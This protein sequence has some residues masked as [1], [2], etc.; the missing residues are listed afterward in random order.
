MAVHFLQQRWTQGHNIGRGNSLDSI[1]LHSHMTLRG[2]VLIY[3][4]DFLNM[5]FHKNFLQQAVSALSAKLPAFNKK[6]LV[7]L[8]GKND[9]TTCHSKI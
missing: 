3:F 9:W 1:H 2:V 8:L 6:V 5:F 4:N 7:G